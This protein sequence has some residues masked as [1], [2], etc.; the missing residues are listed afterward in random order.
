VQW[1][2]KQTDTLEL[3]EADLTLPA[4]SPEAIAHHDGGFVAVLRRRELA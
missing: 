4:T 2:I 3:L 1:L